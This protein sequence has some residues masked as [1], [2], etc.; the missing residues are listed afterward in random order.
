MIGRMRVNTLMKT[1]GSEI[2]IVEV[3]EAEEVAED[4]IPVVEAEAVG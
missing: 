3:V 2:Q 1:R 4:G